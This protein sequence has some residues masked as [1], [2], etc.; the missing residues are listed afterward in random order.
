MLFA[1][2]AL[3]GPAE[4]FRFKY[5]Q[6][7]TYRILSTV[8]EDVLVNGELDHHAEIVNRISVIVTEVQGTKARH[9]VT[10]MT[11]ENS[12]GALSGRHFE[13]GAEY[14]SVF[15]RDQYGKYTMLDTY[16]MPVVR[17]VPLFPEGD[18]PLGGFWAA[19]GEEAHDLRRTF[20]VSRPFKVPFTAQYVYEGTEQTGDGRTLHIITA[21]YTMEFASPRPFL[22][23]QNTEYP[24]KTTG[25]SSQVIYWDNDKGAIDHYSEEFRILITT[26][27]RNSFEFAGTARA[28]VT[29][30]EQRAEDSVADIQAQID[31]QGIQDV[32]VVTDDRGLTLSIENI[33]FDPDSAVLGESEKQTLNK[34]AEILRAFP[35]ND[36]LIS[37]HTAR[38]GTTAMQQQLSEQRAKVIA[39]YL[40]SIGVRDAHQ[41]FTRWFGADRPV[42]S[43]DTE[44]GRVKNRRV[45]ITILDK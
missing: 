14:Q 4:V 17:D 31:S 15:T 2:L 11:A 8:D 21:Q 42:A 13:W 26:S 20:N 9:E 30:Y 45:E 41:V 5:R 38:A 33:N 24:A 44:A 19:K 10:F 39:D 6:G 7:E 12:T 43:N 18:V 1:F 40:V 35:D 16:F 28:E 37:G 32:T 27:A 34:I 23:Q 36:L 25:Q 29:A 22:G 3:P